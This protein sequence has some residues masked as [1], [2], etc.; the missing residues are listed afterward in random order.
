MARR[1]RPRVVAVDPSLSA[2]SSSG[3]DIEKEIVVSRE[4]SRL[5]AASQN[6]EIEEGKGEQDVVKTNGQ[7][8]ARNSQKSCKG[9]DFGRV[10]AG[11]GKTIQEE[12]A[13]QRRGHKY[14]TDCAGLLQQAAKQ[15]ADLGRLLESQDR[16]V[17][18]AVGR[19][20]GSRQASPDGEQQAAGQFAV[21][22]QSK[23]SHS[24]H[25]IGVVGRNSRRAAPDGDEPDD[26]NY[27][28][29]SDGDGVDDDE[30]E[31]DIDDGSDGNSGRHLT[32]KGREKR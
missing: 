13:K 21:L 2:R 16:H 5:P 19:S 31:D 17:T 7:G 9:T 29:D 24:T 28:D 32:A 1:A 4:A 26:A 30:D 14:C 25:A 3:E 6:F 10:L 15:L 20:S 23:E 12:V 22:Q 8:H 27:T 11:V 18:S